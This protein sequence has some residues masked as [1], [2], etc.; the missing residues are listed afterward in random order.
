[1]YFCIDQD[2]RKV[3]DQNGVEFSANQFH[4][5]RERY[6]R[7]LKPLDMTLSCQRLV[8]MNYDWGELEKYY[9]GAV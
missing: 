5:I 2:R 9:S 7:Q 3:I 8:S 1:M 6:E 4:K